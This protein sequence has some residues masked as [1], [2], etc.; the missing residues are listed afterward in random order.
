MN[1]IYGKRCL[2]FNLSGRIIIVPK[3]T[4]VVTAVFNS[5][6]KLY[7]NVDKAHLYT[8]SLKEL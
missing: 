8:C 3:T 7:P 5:Q 4:M 6:Y 1:L 2:P